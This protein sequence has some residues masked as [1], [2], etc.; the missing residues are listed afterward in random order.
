MRKFAVDFY[1]IAQIIN[2]NTCFDYNTF[3]ILPHDWV[4]FI[5]NGTPFIRQLKLETHKKLCN[6]FFILLS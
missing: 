3:P 5:I 6:S 1:T 4:G 2:S